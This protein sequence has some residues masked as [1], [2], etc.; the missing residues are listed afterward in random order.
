VA[1]DRVNRLVLTAKPL[2][3]AGVDQQAMGRERTGASG[4]EQRHRAGVRAEVSRI[5]MGWFPFE[6]MIFGGPAR[7]PAVQ[8]RDRAVAEV[9]Q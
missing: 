3:C 5:G 7:Q 4:I 8:H 1:R 9:A 2:G 6:R